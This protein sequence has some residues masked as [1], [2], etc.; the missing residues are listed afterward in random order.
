MEPAAV[1]A[2][3]EANKEAAASGTG[4][5]KA[6]GQTK[7]RVGTSWFE[8]LLANDPVWKEVVAARGNSYGPKR[9]VTDEEKAGAGY[10][11]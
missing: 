4:K 2:S 11:R 6:V 5:G 3:R 9:P 1:Q 7:A 10:P 8:Q